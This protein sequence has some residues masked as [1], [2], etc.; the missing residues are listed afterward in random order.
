VNPNE[1]NRQNRHS[2]STRRSE[3]L[4]RLWNLKAG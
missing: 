4:A 3:K 1:G 2:L